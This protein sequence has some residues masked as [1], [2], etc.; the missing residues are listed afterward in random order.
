M[1]GQ[2]YPGCTMPNL[3]AEHIVVMSRYLG[4]PLRKGELVHH[5]N[6]VRDDNRIENLELWVKSHPPGQ[7]VSDL[8]QWAKE[9]LSSYEPLALNGDCRVS[10]PFVQAELV[11]KN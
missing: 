3:T 8:V 10:T 9:I 6:G 7:R 11:K 1:S 4:R 5:K 2:W